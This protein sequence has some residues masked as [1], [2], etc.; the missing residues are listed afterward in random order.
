[1]I[2]RNNVVFYIIASDLDGTLLNSSQQITSFTKKILH[3]L[4]ADKNIHFVFA[5]G[6]HHKNVM[7]I[8]NNLN[9]PSYMITS[10]GA[11]I[12][13]TQGDIIA[14]HNINTKIAADLVKIVYYDPKIITN[15]FRNDEWLINRKNKI[16]QE[17]NFQENNI[18]Y[19]LYKKNIA[20]LDGICKIYFASHDHQ[21][22]L[23]LEQELYKKW[24][25][26]INISFSLPTCLEIMPAGISKGHALKKV[27][28]L[29]GYQLKDCISFGDGMNDKEMLAMTGKGCIMCNAQQ[30]LKDTLP[31]LE[32]IG[33][34]EDDAVSH[35]L[36]YLYFHKHNICI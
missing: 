34:N 11:R 29:L 31:H 12:H 21:R 7:K 6:R 33:S 26:Y 20:V 14:V 16:H 2:K 32:I 24:G 8:R 30:R 18:T 15:I 28:N 23:L 9:I 17:K 1:M 13:N 27:A 10:N 3:L 35:Y 19:K 22:L 5:T 25:N 4:T 36:Q